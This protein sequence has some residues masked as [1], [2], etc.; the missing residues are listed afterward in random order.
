[1]AVMG[2]MTLCLIFLCCPLLRIHFNHFN[3]SSLLIRVMRTLTVMFRVPESRSDWAQEP[4]HRNTRPPRTWERRHRGDVSGRDRAPGTCEDMMERGG[5]TVTWPVYVIAN[6]NS[7]GGSRGL[8]Y[9]RG[10]AGLSV[11]QS[12]ARLG[13]G[14]PMGRQKGCD[15][16][17]LDNREV[18]RDTESRSWLSSELWRSQIDR[19]RPQTW[20]AAL[21]VVKSICEHKQKIWHFYWLYNNKGCRSGFVILYPHQFY[22]TSPYTGQAV[23]YCCLSWVE[24]WMHANAGSA[25]IKLWIFIL[26]V[27]AEIRSSGPL[28]ARFLLKTK[29]IKMPKHSGPGPGRH[30]CAK[31]AV[32]SN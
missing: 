1:M 4:G 32:K 15:L 30:F 8:D 31:C 10:E 14:W 23:I 6:Y 7:G 3:N 24:N 29:Q 16:M 22:N 11:R 27:L 2:I 19:G 9:S 25:E 20:S 26:P 13:T 18:T 17:S 28:T 12:E 21:V 5:A